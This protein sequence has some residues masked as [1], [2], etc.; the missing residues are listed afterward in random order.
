[1]ARHL[2]MIG[3][4]IL[5]GFGY[6]YYGP[7]TEMEMNLVDIQLQVADT[8]LQLEDASLTNAQKVNIIKSNIQKA[9][10]A[11]KLEN[12]LLIYRIVAG[13]FVIGGLVLAKIGFWR[14]YTAPRE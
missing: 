10:I 6:C 9:E 11:G 14:L 2:S 7:I 8:E 12:N 1:M 13:V 4:I 3:T 5:V